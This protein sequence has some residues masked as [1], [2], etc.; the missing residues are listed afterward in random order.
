M[1][2]IDISHIEKHLFDKNKHGWDRDQYPL[3]Q[4][5]KDVKV[6]RVLNAKPHK[7]LSNILSFKRHIGG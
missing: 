1:K 7:S 2:E 3:I 5:K 4:I 6:L